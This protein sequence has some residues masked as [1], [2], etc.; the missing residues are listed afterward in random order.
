VGQF[1]NAKGERSFVIK[2]IGLILPASINDCADVQSGQRTEFP[3]P[4]KG[5]KHLSV[6]SKPQEQNEA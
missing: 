6:V 2:A 3:F 5:I 4:R 1:D